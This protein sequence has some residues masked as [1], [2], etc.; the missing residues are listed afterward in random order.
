[1]LHPLYLFEKECATGH[2][3][4]LE[5]YLCQIEQ[6]G[7]RN[8]GTSDN[9]EAK[10]VIGSFLKDS[11]HGDAYH[12]YQEIEPCKS[13]WIIEFQGAASSSARIEGIIG[14]KWKGRAAWRD[15]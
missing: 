1:V 6:G 3:D 9:R 8:Y 7:Y 14:S 10:K 2:S 5:A 4:D 15:P 12:D 11:H 13:L